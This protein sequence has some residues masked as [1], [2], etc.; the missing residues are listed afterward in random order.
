MIGLGLGIALIILI[1][2]VF[3]PK[4]YSNEE[5]NETIPEV[6]QMIY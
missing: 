4:K 5:L 3:P 1:D 6:V 2:C